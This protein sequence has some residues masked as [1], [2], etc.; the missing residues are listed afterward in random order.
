M[1]IQPFIKRGPKPKY[2]ND[3]ERKEAVRMSMAK[4][5]AKYQKTEKYKNYMRAKRKKK[6]YELLS[7]YIETKTD[8]HPNTIINPNDTMKQM[9]EDFKEQ[10]GIP[11][12]NKYIK[13]H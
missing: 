13:G 1:Y 9:R 3:D 6:L 5:N 7:E 11:I 2:M 4:A 12:Y 8:D 10:Y